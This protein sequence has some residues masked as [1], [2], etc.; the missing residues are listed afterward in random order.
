MDIEVMHKINLFKGLSITV[1]LVVTCTAR[2]ARKIAM[3][4]E[5]VCQMVDYELLGLVHR[6]GRE[7]HRI[8]GGVH[9][10]PGQGGEGEG[11]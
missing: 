3:A 11:A 9:Q 7:V 8:A 2:E 6:Y 10:P 4:S 5:V 1:L